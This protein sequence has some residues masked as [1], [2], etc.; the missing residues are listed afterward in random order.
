MAGLSQF[1]IDRTPLSRRSTGVAGAGV[2]WGVFTKESNCLF[3][4]Y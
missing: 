1:S 2:E 4:S 3:V